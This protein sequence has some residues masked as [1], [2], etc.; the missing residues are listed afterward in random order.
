VSCFWATMAEEEEQY[1]TIDDLLAE[2]DAQQL[3]SGGAIRSVR[4]AGVQTSNSWSNHLKQLHSSGANRRRPADLHRAARQTAAETEASLRAEIL[5]A[6]ARADRAEDSS[7]A[8]RDEKLVII[9]LE[10]REQSCNL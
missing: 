2:D 7:R 9:V 6:E 10:P 4:E 3:Q 1:F 5:A 8:L